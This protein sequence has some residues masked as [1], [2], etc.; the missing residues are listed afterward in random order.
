MA[1]RAR[2][3]TATARFAECALPLLLADMRVRHRRIGEEAIFDA[4]AEAILGLCE[5]PDRWLPEKASLRT[6]LW[7]SATGDLKNELGRAS[8]RAQ[9]EKVIDP[10]EIAQLRRNIT[11]E[12]E[13]FEGDKNDVV[14]RY[15]HLLAD[16]GDREVFRLMV[17]GERAET[18]YVVALG[19]SLLPAIERKRRVKQAKDR[20][21]K[22]LQRADVVW[23]TE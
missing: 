14:S 21:K 4:C 2:D 9:R 12:A 20:V 13:I 23:P 6:F 17:S 22:R 7:M 8:L 1:I 11:A 5:A 16:A 19:I 15:E 18:A 3:S 10:V